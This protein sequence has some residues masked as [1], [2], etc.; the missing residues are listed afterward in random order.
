MALK[1]IR[2]C[3]PDIFISDV[4][5]PDIKISEVIIMHVVQDIGE[6]KKI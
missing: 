3:K 2:V 5:M 4:N 1:E 6:A